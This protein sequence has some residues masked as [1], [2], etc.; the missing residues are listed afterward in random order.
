MPDDSDSLAVAVMHW[1]VVC[2]TRQLL[3]PTATA[4]IHR[5]ILTGLTLNQ[6]LQ[7]KRFL[8]ELVNQCGLC[9]VR[10]PRAYPWLLVFGGFR[11]RSGL[12]AGI[13]IASQ[14]CLLCLFT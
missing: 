1:I 8:A 6:L 5:A 9:Q 3:H 4:P 13:H 2:S 12:C 10:Q 14:S 11:V 7:L